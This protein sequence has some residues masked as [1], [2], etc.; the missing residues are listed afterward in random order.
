MTE[1][2]NSGFNFTS[3]GLRLKSTEKSLNNPLFVHF[4]GLYETRDVCKTL[5]PPPLETS[6]EKT[7]TKNY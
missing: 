4:R 1:E 7:E 2:K 5:L 6:V 3:T